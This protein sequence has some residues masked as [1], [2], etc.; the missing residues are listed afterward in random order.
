MS[1]LDTYVTSSVF[2]CI[3]FLNFHSHSKICH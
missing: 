3:F 2:T 1:A